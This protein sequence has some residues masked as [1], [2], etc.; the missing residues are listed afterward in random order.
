[1]LSVLLAAAVSDIRTGRISNQLIFAGLSFG[2]IFRV[3][4]MGAFGIAVFIIHI[5]IPVILFS[6]LFLMRVLGA[7]DIKL[8]SVIS[9]VCTYQQLFYCIVASFLAGAVLALLKTGGF[10]K[11]RVRILYFTLYVTD[12]IRE[13]KIIPYPYIFGHREETIPFSAAILLGYLISLGG[14]R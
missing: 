9:S 4:N 7:G 11:L 5:T 3:W 8:F 14:C 12:V 6:V 13:R 2:I 1:M 10:K